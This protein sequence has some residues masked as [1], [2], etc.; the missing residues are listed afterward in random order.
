MKITK[1]QLKKIIIEEVEESYERAARSTD[2]VLAQA[3]AP[4]QIKLMSGVVAIDIKFK[5]GE[6]AYYELKMDPDDLE[7]VRD[8]ISG[9]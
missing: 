7:E 9:G 6:E 2:T 4:V 8:L 5:N 3:T 1:E